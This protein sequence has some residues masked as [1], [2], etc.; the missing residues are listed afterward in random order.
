MR[1]QKDDHG[2]SEQE[3]GVKY[4]AVKTGNDLTPIGGMFYWRG[5]A[6]SGLIDQ[7]GNALYDNPEDSFAD[8]VGIESSIAMGLIEKIC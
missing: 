1:G 4:R 8:H 2:N 7:A 5:R 6:F 3:S